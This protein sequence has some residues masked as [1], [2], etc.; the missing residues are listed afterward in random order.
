[1]STVT[2]DKPSAAV[3]R[4]VFFHVTGRRDLAQRAAA[5]ASGLRFAFHHSW[6]EDPGEPRRPLLGGQPPVG[7]WLWKDTA[8]DFAAQVNDVLL[9]FVHPLLARGLPFCL[10][11]PFA[12]EVLAPRGLAIAEAARLDLEDIGRLLDDACSVP[13]GRPPEPSGVSRTASS[14]RRR[15]GRPR[16]PR[17]PAAR[18]RAPAPRDSTTPSAPPSSTG[19]A[20]PGS[21]PQRAPARPRPS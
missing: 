18:R 11:F 5:A 19:A 3:P 4:L 17:P 9:R 21:S 15:G 6:T 16:P 2:A 10:G 1:M 12:P 20:P 13:A 8:D 7:L 14:R